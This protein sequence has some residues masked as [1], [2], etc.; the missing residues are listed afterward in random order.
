MK[1]T[2]IQFTADR[3]KVTAIRICMADKNGSIETELTDFI[4]TLYKKYVPQA[5]RDY[6]EKSELANQTE[7]QSKRGGTKRVK[8]DL[9]AVS[10]GVDNYPSGDN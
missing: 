6:I 3:D 10:T 7:S 4:D 8:R 2:T 1:E 5:V 9:S